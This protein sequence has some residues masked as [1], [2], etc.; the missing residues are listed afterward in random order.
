MSSITKSKG[1]LRVC[2]RGADIVRMGKEKFLE[3]KIIQL[4]A[5]E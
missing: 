5:E 2:V 1:T 3:K 4:R